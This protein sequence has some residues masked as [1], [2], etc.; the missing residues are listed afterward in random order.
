MK[1]KLA[2]LD[3]R[4]AYGAPILVAIAAMGPA[5]LRLGHPGMLGGGDLEMGYLPMW[6]FLGQSLRAGHLPLW[7]PTLGGGLPFVALLPS[8]GLYPP[9]MLLFAALPL[10]PGALAFIVL[11][12]AWAGLG[13]AWLGRRFGHERRVAVCAG[14]LVA[15]SPVLLG[16]VVRTNVFATACWLP[17]IVAATHRA[18]GGGRGSVAVLSACVACGVL[19]GTPEVLAPAALFAFA[20]AVDAVRRS[21]WRGVAR[22]VA[23]GTLGV[24]L[25]MPAVLPFAELLVRSSRRV[26]GVVWPLHVRELPALFVP[27]VPATPYS[28]KSEWLEGPVQRLLPFLYLGAPVVFLGGVALLRRERRASLWAAT[29]VAAIALAMFGGL[30][31]SLPAAL[32][33]PVL[34]WRYPI[35]LLIP[36]VFSAAL[37]A[38]AGASGLATSRPRWLR[39]VAIVVG[40][41]AASLGAWKMAEWGIAAVSCFWIGATVSLL[42]IVWRWLPGGRRALVGMMA[43]CVVD[44]LGASW[45]HR[46][47]PTARAVDCGTVWARVGELAGAGRVW[48][49][50]P[51]PPYDALA[52]VPD[53]ELPL[54]YRRALCL[55]GDHA[56]RYGIDA[57]AVYGSVLPRSHDDFLARTGVKGAALL[58]ATIASAWSQSDLAGL[59]EVST[60]WPPAVLARLPEAAPRVEL[61]ADA[62]VT[63][64]VLGATASST[65][66]ELRHTVLLA[67]PP[68]AATAP[69]DPYTGADVARMLQDDGSALAI[70][71]RSTGERYLVLADLDYPGWRAYVDGAPVPIATAY[72]VMRAVHLGPGRHVVRFAYC[73][74]A[75]Y[76]GLACAAAALLALALPQL[77][78]AVRARRSRRSHEPAGASVE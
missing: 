36:A 4:L 40:L 35:K 16:A 58:G 73:P 61:R 69:G 26:H 44:A 15:A 2:R 20:L 37:L 47:P 6:R 62:R 1:P 48:V 52:S 65:L 18:I 7:M 49:V 25:A 50:D 12:L 24:M 13:T 67:A 3:G 70:E 14:A 10:V 33:L 66:A 55:S 76:V 22:F 28:T 68:P 32:H 23:G 46:L 63:S 11:H 56:A 43:V 60:F 77:I 17:W 78:G 9:A 19:A 74:L 59:P 51:A 31:N 29:I 30:T 71:T 8:Q 5:L 27:F 75:F 38:S 57:L 34:R 53:D 54:A 42:A 72:G 64:D 45:L 39:P 21:S 41:A